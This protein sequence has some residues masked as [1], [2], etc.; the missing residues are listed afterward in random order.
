MRMD[1]QEKRGLPR[2]L[3]CLL[4]TMA[5]LWGM[6]PASA[7]ASVSY[8]KMTSGDVNIRKSASTGSSILGKTTRGQVFQCKGSV[9]KD[10]I[11]WYKIVYK[12][13][14]AY[15]AS[16]YAKSSNEKEY[17]YYISRTSSKSTSSSSKSSSSSSSSKSSSSS[18]SSGIEKG[19][20]AK[21][22]KDKVVIRG[23]ASS[24]G[25]QVTSVSKKGTAVTLQGKT[26]KNDGYT[27]YSV[28]AN[29][30]TGWV[31]GDLIKVLSKSD[32]DA[33]RKKKTGSKTLFEPELVDWKKDDIY[34]ILYKGCVATLTDVKTGISFKIKR[35][36]GGLHAD[37]E[38]LTSSDTAKMCKVYGVKNAQQISD[39]NMYQRRSVLITFD[40]HTYAASMYG[41]PHNYPAGDTLPNNKY[42][43][44]FCIHFINSQVH[45]SKKVDAAHQKAIKYA[46]K[47]GEQVL[48]QYGYTFR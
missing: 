16:Q 26:K 15:V 12:G 11:K 42:N 22:K 44:Q 1:T 9:K 19:R 7:L 24:N 39:Y 28:K 4:V 41:V 30:V 18:S 35:W 14:T 2:R 3:L 37:V 20:I 32:S 5:L 8:I 27:W 43:G 31:R 23:S 33:Y 10:D 46:Y 21:T 25:K 38:P 48:S 40:G 17:D 6:L 36:S 47:Y 29:G 45:K 34:K 13:G